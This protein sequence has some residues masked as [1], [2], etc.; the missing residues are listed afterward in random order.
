MHRTGQLLGE[1]RSTSG[2]SS[3]LRLQ[4][5]LHRPSS[6]AW[7]PRDCTRAV[8]LP[9]RTRAASAR[10]RFFNNREPWGAGFPSGG[11][12]SRFSSARTFR[13][14]HG[15]PDKSRSGLLAVDRRPWSGC[16]ISAVPCPADVADVLARRRC[17][18][19]RSDPVRRLLR[20]VE[21][22]AVE[23]H[24]A[25]WAHVAHGQASDSLRNSS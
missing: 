17:S 2:K 19:R 7:R 8:A 1:R 11:S 22:P 21:P 24:S 9:N 12:P 3:I 10:L 6:P 14:A 4:L 18:L 20:T 5:L 16:G 13:S 23:R 15:R 25:A